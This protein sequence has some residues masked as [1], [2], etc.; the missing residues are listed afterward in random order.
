[1]KGI[2]FRQELNI[3]N[4]TLATR[5]KSTMCSPRKYA[6]AGVL[7]TG[8]KELVLSLWSHV[9]IGAGF[10]LV[11][12]SQSGWRTYCTRDFSVVKSVFD[13]L[14]NGTDPFLNFSTVK[15]E[16][17]FDICKDV[18]GFGEVPVVRD[19]KTARKSDLQLSAVHELNQS[20]EAIHHFN[21]A[22]L[23]Q[24]L[25]SHRIQTETYLGMSHVYKIIVDE[26]H[27]FRVVVRAGCLGRAVIRLCFTV[28]KDAIIWK[29]G[30][31]P[32]VHNVY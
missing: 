11:G 14:P 18:F 15:T 9:L 23:C 25:L 20:L 6:G 3:L 10:K 7:L 32:A 27:P 16:G 8:Q 13:C 21:R 1:M 29:R 17:M 24:K 31:K 12:I 19:I 4:R 26:L 22:G 5:I 2:N 30:K 28:Q